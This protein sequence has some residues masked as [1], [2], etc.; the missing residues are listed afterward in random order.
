[1]SMININYLVEV[2]SSEYGVIRPYKFIIKFEI[3]N[4]EISEEKIVC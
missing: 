1:M 4:F 2:A 3:E